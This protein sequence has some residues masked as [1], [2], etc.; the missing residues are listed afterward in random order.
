[1]A[2]VAQGWAAPAVVDPAPVDAPGTPDALARFV[3]G[4]AALPGAEYV[5]VV[6]AE[7]ER[8]RGETGGPPEADLAVLAWARRVASVSRERRQTFEDLV[9]TTDTAFHLVRMVPVDPGAPESDAAWVTVRID[10]ARGNLAWS[11]RTLAGL[12]APSATAGPRALTATSSRDQEPAPGPAAGRVPTAGPARGGSNGTILAPDASTAP[13]AHPSFRS[14]SPAAP[15]SHQP[16]PRFAPFEPTPP[17]APWPRPAATSSWPTSPPRPAARFTD[18][19]P[20]RATGPRSFAERPVAGAPLPWTHDD[21]ADP[22]S[23]ALPAALPTGEQAPEVPAPRP[24]GPDE[25]PRTAWPRLEDRTARGVDPGQGSGHAWPRLEDRPVTPTPT[26]L[27]EL[28]V[29]TPVPEHDGAPAAR[30]LP[31]NIRQAAR[32][33]DDVDEQPAAPDGWVP[34]ARTST[35]SASSVPAP[36]AGSLFTPAVPTSTPA[37]APP[38]APLVVAPPPAPT[39]AA[40]TPAAPTRVTLSPAQERD[41]DTGEMDLPLRASAV[42]TPRPYAP[43]PGRAPAPEPWPAATTPPPEPEPD[44]DPSDD[45]PDLP[46]RRPGANLAPGLPATPRSAPTVNPVAAVAGTAAFSTEH[47]VLRRLLDGLRRLS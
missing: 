41:D 43:K 36:R 47:S 21:P 10:R 15:D 2:L 11:R 45:L 30:R 26:P 4:L 34:A 5:L 40:P 8:V 19:E 22:G 6:D 1:M 3:D 31:L 37:A 13:S 23:G 32:W 12:G 24:A 27:A 39:P 7:G 14:A 20:L 42:I 35:E 29:S 33:R 38:V 28:S 17:S 18:P 46:R 44:P 9:L 16:S 25:R